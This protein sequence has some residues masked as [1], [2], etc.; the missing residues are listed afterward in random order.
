MTQPEKRPTKTSAPDEPSEFSVKTSFEVLNSHSGISGVELIAK[1]TPT[2]P[3]LDDLRAAVIQA[4]TENSNWFDRLHF[5]ELCGLSTG[6]IKKI[7]GNQKNPLHGMKMDR[8]TK[9]VIGIGRSMQDF[10]FGLQNDILL[11]KAVVTEMAKRRSSNGEDFPAMPSESFLQGTLK[12]IDG[13]L[14]LPNGKQLSQQAEFC[15]WCARFEP[16]SDK[17]FSGQEICQ[18]QRS[19]GDWFA[20]LY[21]LNYFQAL[22]HRRI[23]FHMIN[24]TALENDAQRLLTTLS[25]LPLILKVVQDNVSSRLR[26]QLNSCDTD[27]FDWG[28]VAERASVKHEVLRDYLDKFEL[29]DKE[30][31]RPGTTPG[32]ILVS[33]PVTF[34]QVQDLLA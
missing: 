33:S 8:I 6:E 25:T 18:M 2:L 17:I 13:S 7:F 20:C 14:P 1:D 32:W 12:L 5:G 27:S 21:N 4:F 10:D 30:F 15:S 23:S 16:L 31:I 19:V 26:P 34:P 11:K 29:S 28:A 22:L 3:G 9:I 24:K